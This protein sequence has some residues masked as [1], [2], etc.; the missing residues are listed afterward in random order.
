MADASPLEP[1]PTPAA[2]E[3]AAN[4]AP[5]PAS[6]P[7]PAAG[8]AAPAAAQPAPPPEPLRADEEADDEAEAR[9]FEQVRSQRERLTRMPDGPRPPEPGTSR[10][11]WRRRQYVVDWKIQMSYAGLYIA[12]LTLFIVGFAAS[13]LIF[14]GLAQ[15]VRQSKG[16]PQVYPW[17]ADDWGYYLIL[18]FVVLLFVGMGMAFWAI[19]HSHRI[20]GPALRLRRAFRQMLRRDYDFHIQLRKRDYLQ[21][22]ADQV[23]VLNN[24]LKAKDVVVSDAALRVEAL[25]RATEDPEKAEALREVARDLADVVLPLPEPAE[26][27]AE[28]T[29]KV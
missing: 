1:S 14:R 5:A 26:G 29:A 6:L 11:N 16:L 22:L 24:A 28:T 13:N 23:N 10:P 20:A 25:A 3:P 15:I 2:P 21:D 7:P 19:V 8:P 12:T 17:L 4:A 18:N 27:D 9:A